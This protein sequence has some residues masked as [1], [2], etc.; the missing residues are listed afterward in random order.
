MSLRLLLAGLLKIL[1]IRYSIAQ[2]P[3]LGGGFGALSG[4]KY[5]F[6]PSIGMDVRGLPAGSLSVAGT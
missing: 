1:H 3:L 2:S 4:N 5:C 6:G